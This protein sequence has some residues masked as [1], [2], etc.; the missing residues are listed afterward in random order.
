MQ[1]P[2]L[3][4]IMPTH[5][6]ARQPLAPG[7]I[8]PVGWMRLPGWS[9]WLSYQFCRGWPADRFSL[10]AKRG[11]VISPRVEGNG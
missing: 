1:P 3:G 11:H 10:S 7:S 8:D 9:V 4:A 5:Q 6:P 2:P